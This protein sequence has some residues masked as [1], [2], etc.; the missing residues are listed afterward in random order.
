M[1]KRKINAYTLMEIT[2][3]MLLAAICISVCYSAY[4]LINNY[5]NAFKKKNV[6]N[7]EVLTLNGTMDRDFLKANYIIRTADGMSIESPNQ[8]IHYHFVGQEVIRSVS[9]LR[10]DSFHL[11]PVNTFFSFRGH[12]V[13]EL[14]TIDQV[15]LY[16]NIDGKRKISIA[17]N[18]QYS[19]CDLLR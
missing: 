3:S 17:K 8:L 15:S 6:L 19:A 10:T 7:Q 14:D 11:S 12:E 18:K 2:V 16:I 1:I 4:G 9:G 13:N 5:F